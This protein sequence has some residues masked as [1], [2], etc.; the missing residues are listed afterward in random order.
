MGKL[1]ISETDLIKSPS[2]YFKFKLGIQN[3]DK[4]HIL[5]VQD[6]VNNVIF[7]AELIKNSSN[8]TNT[9][10]NNL[11]FIKKHF[12]KKKSDG[13]YDSSVFD[14]KKFENKMKGVTE[15]SKEEKEVKIVKKT[16]TDKANDMRLISKYF[17][18]LRLSVLKEKTKEK[19]VYNSMP[20][21][22]PDKLTDFFFSLVLFPN[23]ESNI[24]FYNRYVGFDTLKLTPNFKFKYSQSNYKLFD[25]NETQKKED[26]EVSAEVSANTT[27]GKPTVVVNNLMTETTEVVTE[28]SKEE[29]TKK[30]D[31]KEN[32]TDVKEN[33]TDVKENKNDVKVKPMVENTA[34]V[35]EKPKEN[36]TQETADEGKASPTAD[37]NKTNNTTSNSNETLKNE[38][39]KNDKIIEKETIKNETP[40]SAEKIENKTEETN[41]TTKS[42]IPKSN[43]TNT[44]TTES[45][46][47]KNIDKINSTKT[48]N[49]NSQ[50]E[51]NDNSVQNQPFINNENQNNKNVNQVNNNPNQTNNNNLNQGNNNNP[52]QANNNNINQNN[53][54]PNQANNNNNFN[55]INQQNRNPNQNNNNLNQPNNNNNNGNPQNNANQNNLTNDIKDK[56]N[57]LNQQAKNA[58]NS[59]VNNAENNINQVKDNLANKAKLKINEIIPN[60]NSNSTIQRL[61][62]NRLLQ[63]SNTTS[64]KTSKTIDPP[65]ETIELNK[66]ES[67]EP[68]MYVYHFAII[69]NFY[70]AIFNSQNSTFEYNHNIT[71]DYFS[72]HYSDIKSNIIKELKETNIPLK[73]VKV[74]EFNPKIEGCDSKCSIPLG[75]SLRANSCLSCS[76]GVLN[77]S[78]HRCLEFCP[79]NLKNSGGVCI[80]CLDDDCSE[81]PKVEMTI[82]RKDEGIFLV[83]MNQ[84]VLN[85]TKPEMKK[86]LKAELIGVKPEF[87]TYKVEPISDNS[88]EIELMINETLYNKR[89]KISLDKK[90]LKEK[91]LYDENYNEVQGLEKSIHIGT[92]TYL[93]NSDK[94]WVDF[95]SYFI[96]VLF[97]LTLLF[98]LIFF[99]INCKSEVPLTHYVCKKM[100]RFACK[101]QFTAFLIFL[102]CQMSPQLRRFLKNI[103]TYC[104]GFTQIFKTV[105]RQEYINHLWRR[106]VP[107]YE[108]H[109]NF[110]EHEV[111]RFFLQNFGLIVII[112][113]TFLLVFCI[114]GIFQCLSSRSSKMFNGCCSRVKN[115]FSLNILILFFLFQIPIYVFVFLNLKYL[116]FNETSFFT[117]SSIFTIIYIIAF[118]IF[119]SMII[120]VFNKKDQL[121]DGSPKFSSK[122]FYSVSYYLLGFK[123]RARTFYFELVYIFFYLTHCAFLVFLYKWPSIHVL[124]DATLVFIFLLIIVVI[125][126]FKRRVEFF[127][128]VAWLSLLMIVYVALSFM[129]YLDLDNRNSL[130]ER[131]II[132]WITII[133]LFI[134]LLLYFIHMV[135]QF[136]KF[137]LDKKKNA[138]VRSI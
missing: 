74:K 128:E 72:K 104:V 63:N 100:V 20:F 93:K 114:L 99:I 4:F 126:P 70:G 28:K 1:N 10:N 98:L 97:F 107:V 89:L 48:N 39:P 7:R 113:G 49:D 105:N 36:P 32:T 40:K 137:Y 85:M 57:D 66:D 122:K 5:S 27:E 84:K 96:I 83:S 117:A 79:N 71:V 26:K 29:D 19:E 62:N 138:N 54:N 33:T 50:N 86:Y 131:N 82:D 68:H 17:Y 34:V 43:E 115:I 21:I 23:K 41:Q 130:F 15:T 121:L 61:T 52:N 134:G 91:Q 118:I 16:E 42:E 101:V 124:S 30:T 3:L 80:P 64:K 92:M 102:N 109:I 14:S 119:V 25:H 13:Y 73:G 110:E 22:F 44:N 125:R 116:S 46:N 37:N 111:F 45:E 108:R 129:T 2:F 65:K 77:S 76:G 94:N 51:K 31:V 81:K 95:F 56:V 127:I 59:F 53:R 11:K 12:L 136:I 6:D 87:Y 24:V 55:N 88:A 103:Y 106:P 78:D 58:A 123:R 112:H 135:Y 67:G 75:D 90:Y 132:G 18:Y 8:D 133:I 9:F 35:T 38:T 47:T 69:E 60:P 120:I